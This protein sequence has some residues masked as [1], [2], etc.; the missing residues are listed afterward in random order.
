M[1]PGVPGGVGPMGLAPIGGGGGGTGGPPCCGDWGTDPGGM[2]GLCNSSKK[3]HP[4]NL[5]R[6]AHILINHGP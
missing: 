5:P 4:L 3:A 2:P 1:V 6:I